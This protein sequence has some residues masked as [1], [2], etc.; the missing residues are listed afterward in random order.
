MTRSLGTLSMLVLSAVASLVGPGALHDAAAADPF[1][2]KHALVIGIDG[3]R[4]DALQAAKAPNIKGLAASG[5]VC[6]SAFAGGTEGT[7]T[8]QQT[9][10]GPSWSSILTGV[11]VDKHQVP[12]NK[13]ENANLKRI[14]DG[15]IVG[16]P[17]FFTRIKEQQPN[18][19]LASIVNWKP[20]N[21]KILTDA[22][23]QGNGND[24]A[25]TQ[26][27]VELLQGDANPSVIFLQ[28][29]ELD[30]AGHKNN[31]GPTI[32]AYMEAV[33]KIDRH[34]GTILEA[35]HKRPHYGEEDWLILVTAD[36]GGFEKHHGKQR[37]ELRTVF[38]VASGGGYP[39]QVVNG[40]W[41]IVAIPPTVFRHLGLA[42]DPAWG[43]ESAPFAREAAK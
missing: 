3:C 23:Y 2:G 10:S 15:K 27:C 28:F 32:P 12:D 19:Y 17:H 25:V 41:G 9:S 22:D 1:D 33:E 18:C 24:E 37:P 8:Q 34:V 38:L 11:W 42:I 36:H 7:P 14:V 4:S 29:D 13:F 16:Y 5:T 20:I 30:G 35:L 31:Y 40:T 26:Q 39:H 43:W 21:E 6:W